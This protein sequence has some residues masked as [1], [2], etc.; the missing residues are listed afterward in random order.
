MPMLVIRPLIFAV[1]FFVI[2]AFGNILVS[3]YL[4]EL[5]EDRAQD[6]DTFKPGSRINILEDDN[7]PYSPEA[8]EGFTPTA[9]GQASIG[10]IPD[11]SDDDLGDISELSERDAF[12]PAAGGTVPGID[13]DAKESYTD[14]GG[15]GGSAEP[16]FSGLFGME[17]SASSQE[18]AAGKGAN[19]SSKT[20][21]KSGAKTGGISNSDE[22]LPDL[23]I[24]AEA[25]MSEPS[26][27]GS[28]A[29]EYSVSAPPRKPSSAKAPKWA[30]DLNAKEIAMGLR[31]V[32]KKDKEG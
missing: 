3:R 27:E 10:A 28:E 23:D 5:L 9:S 13:Q 32:L 8:P 14:K 25:F 21:A 31:T 29:N 17:A 18:R 20:G 11:D 26:N 24:M 12:Y 30:G 1:I 2:T 6:E 22:T 4:P 15:L 19:A 7:Q 16:D